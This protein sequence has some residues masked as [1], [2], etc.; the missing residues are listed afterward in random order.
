[1]LA[2][3]HG[4]WEKPKWPARVRTHLR[5]NLSGLPS[6]RHRRTAIRAIRELPFP[7]ADERLIAAAEID[8]L[9]ALLDESDLQSLSGDVAWPS[10]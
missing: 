4:Y 1:M 9:E 8:G 6:S 5:V 10:R 2:D 3:E 7:Y